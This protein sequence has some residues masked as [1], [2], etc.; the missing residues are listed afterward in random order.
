MMNNEAN[1]LFLSAPD[2]D[3][4]VE[5]YGGTWA[6]RAMVPLYSADPARFL[7][8]IAAANALIDV[9]VSEES[10]WAKEYGIETVRDFDECIVTNVEQLAIAEELVSENEGLPG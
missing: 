8:R 5:L 1:Y 4:Q 3:N 2:P 10:R 6:P 7:R 9:P